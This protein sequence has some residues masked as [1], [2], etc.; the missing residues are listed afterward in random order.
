MRSMFCIIRQC[1]KAEPKIPKVKFLFKI[2]IKVLF[3]RQGTSLC[4]VCHVLAAMLCLQNCF[5]LYIVDFFLKQQ[6]I[7][8]YLNFF[9]VVCSLQSLTLNRCVLKHFL[10]SFFHIINSLSIYHIILCAWNNQRSIVSVNL[11]TAVHC[12]VL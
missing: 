6:T 1:Q 7:S 8:H 10:S 11:V 3:N 2:I 12:T 4:S 5:D 9:V